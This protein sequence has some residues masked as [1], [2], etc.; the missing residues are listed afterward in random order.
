LQ[1]MAGRNE[2]SDEQPL[3]LSG[4]AWREGRN[5]ML[6]KC[7]PDALCEFTILATPLAA[8]RAQVREALERPR[9]RVL[10]RCIGALLGLAIGDALGS[11]LEFAPLR[12]GSTDLQEMGQSGFW[13]V[14]PDYVEKRP[15][16]NA[17]GYNYFGLKPGQWTDDT[18]MALC[19]ADSLLVNRGF[20]AL[21]L[22]LRFLNWWQFGYNSAFRMDMERRKAFP[23]GSV[24]LGGNIG[25]SLSEFLDAQDEYTK[26][27][28]QLTSGNGSLMRLAPCAIFFRED[29]QK[30]LMVAEQQSK[31]THHGDEAAEC[32][33]L[34][35]YL[36]VG[37]F[38]GP[39]CNENVS[40]ESEYAQRTPAS[41]AP[42]NESV[43]S[44]FEDAQKTPARAAG[45]KAAAKS[46]SVASRSGM[47]TRPGR[48]KQSRGRSGSRGRSPSPGLPERCP[49]AE[50]ASADALKVWLLSDWCRSFPS[51]LHSVQCLA[52]SRM[53]S[54]P[55]IHNTGRQL[56]KGEWIVTTDS[57]NVYKLPMAG[58]TLLEGTLPKGTHVHVEVV[59]SEFGNIHGPLEGWITLY[60]VDGE[61]LLERPDWQQERDWNWQVDDFKYAPLRSH[62]SPD[63][64]GSY[65][66]DNLSM[67]LHCVWTTTSFSAAVLKAANLCGDA[68]TVAAVVGQLAGAIYGASAVPSKWQKQLNCWDDGDIA[69]KAWLLYHQENENLLSQAVTRMS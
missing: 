61:M 10:D 66:M 41:A 2:M 9:D 38:H 8:E 64:I 14:H 27:G 25:E 55:T 47:S 46:K 11:P 24:G 48:E 68:D 52:A 67:A 4:S 69:L 45:A 36:L 32:C 23:C 34:L 60:G 56:E 30:A 50:R 29:L 18:S 58:S 21:D 6:K 53:E 3:W 44:D 59:M 17:L 12:Y 49:S 62:D 7:G 22:R 40:N 54:K 16:R 31:T 33:R 57:I 20:N 13:D 42:C 65:A 28:S 37:A 43:K 35:A 26:T 39:P 51:E 63:Y 1:L 15:I 19:L 5:V